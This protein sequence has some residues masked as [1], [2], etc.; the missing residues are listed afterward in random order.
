MF[1]VIKKRNSARD[2][3]FQDL[4]PAKQTDLSPYCKIFFFPT[5]MLPLVACRVFIYL[6]IVSRKIKYLWEIRFVNGSMI[7]GV[8][9]SKEDRV[10]PTMWKKQNLVINAGI[11]EESTTYEVSLEAWYEPSSKR[12][13]IT[14]ERKTG[15]LPY[16]GTCIAT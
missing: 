9:K 4:A 12:T 16:G 3:S 13:V 10:T 5:K 15:R 1:Y 7:P 14:M 8:T 11:L 2:L 6:R